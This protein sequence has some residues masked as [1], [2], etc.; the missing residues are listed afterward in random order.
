MK[1]ICVF[2]GSASGVDPAYAKAARQTGEQ[3]VQRG[4]GLVYGGGHVGLMGVVADAVL[5]Q[6]GYVFGVI[7]EDLMGREVGHR[8]LS[9]LQIV[10]TMHERKT[11]M[12]ERADAFLILPG[13][14]GTL[15]EFFEEWTWAV[16]GDHTKPIGLVNTAGYYD[17]LITFLD[18]MVQQGFL[19]EKYR[20]LLIVGSTV[21][22]TLT[23][24]GI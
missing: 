19:K 18:H 6:G 2:C 21:E 5:A 22:E 17:D 15:E 16:L 20:R 4:F 11:I 13:G 14:I 12:A 7:T 8:G 23:G 24:M 9:E 3:L 10:R 1:N